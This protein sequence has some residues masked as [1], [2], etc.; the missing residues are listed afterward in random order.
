MYSYNFTV[1]KTGHSEYTIY[2]DKGISM[3]VLTNCVL[4]D[5]AMNRARV[6]ASSWT[7]VNVR[8]EDEQHG[9]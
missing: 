6:W 2:S 9:K 7:S 5:E 4:G 8:M 1:K 3:H